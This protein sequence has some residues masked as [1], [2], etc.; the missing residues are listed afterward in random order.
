MVKVYVVNENDLIEE[1]VETDSVQ[2]DPRSAKRGFTQIF[3]RRKFSYYLIVNLSN[4]YSE[5][6]SV[7]KYPRLLRKIEIIGLIQIFIYKSEFIQLK[8]NGFLKTGL[9]MQFTSSYKPPVGTF[10]QLIF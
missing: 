8:K 1:T 5:S 10:Q 2:I 9:F 7:I 6:T 3:G 4:V